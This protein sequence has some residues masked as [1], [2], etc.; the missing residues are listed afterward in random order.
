M[1][2]CSDDQSGLRVPAAGGVCDTE[3]VAKQLFT[4]LSLDNS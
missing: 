1:E 3:S 2:A 4:S